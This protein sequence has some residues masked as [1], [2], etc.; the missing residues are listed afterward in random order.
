MLP[1]LNRPVVDYVVADCVKAGVKEIIFVVLPGETQLRDYYSRNQ[2]LE[3][4]LL[5][6]KAQD[7]YD[8]IADVHK[9]AEFRFIEQ[10]QDSRYGTAIPPLLAKEFIEQDEAFLVLMGDD[11]IFNK[12]GS[13]E[14]AR[15]IKTYENS[16]AAAAMACAEVPQRELSKYGVVQFS[17]NGIHDMF[18]AIIEKPKADSAP[19]NLINISKY[20][21][22]YGI[23]EY[24]KRVKPDSSSGEHYII[25]A[26]N[27][28]V[29]H[30][31][32]TAIHKITGQYLDAGT[33]EGWLMANQ[34]LAKAQGL[35]K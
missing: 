5:D 33:V 12:D 15:L 18:E 22:T 29:A 27:E 4:Y 13:S 30:K 11:F 14:V 21:F 3:D 31:K 2:K 25:D 35:L 7:K 6:R 28:Q 19:S 32:Q 16:R 26:V 1:I 9:Q 17:K 34:V 20:V 8:L 24:L 23:F 10:P